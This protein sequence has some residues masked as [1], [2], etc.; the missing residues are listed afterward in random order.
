MRIAVGFGD[1]VYSGP[2][3]ADLPAMLD[4]PGPRMLCRSRE[5][6]GTKKLEPMV[7]LDI[8]NSRMK[9]VYDIRLLSRQFNFDGSEENSPLCDSDYPAGASESKKTR[10]Q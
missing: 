7:K 6:T 10:R 8:L 9:A 3:P 4:F 1:V 5:G 2:E